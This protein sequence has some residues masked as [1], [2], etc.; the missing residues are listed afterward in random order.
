MCYCDLAEVLGGDGLGVEG[1]HSLLSV[2]ANGD[3]GSAGEQ[4]E[5]QQQLDDDGGGVGEGGGDDDVL[6]GEAALVRSC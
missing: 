2:V 4:G 1:G 6:G 5:L 3:Q